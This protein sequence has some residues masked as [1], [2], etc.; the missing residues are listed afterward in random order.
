[1]RLTRSSRLV[2]LKVEISRR[3][4]LIVKFVRRFTVV[5]CRPVPEVIPFVRRAG[6]DGDDSS[7]R[8]VIA[9][10]YPHAYVDERDGP[11]FEPFDDE[12]LACS[13]IDTDKYKTQSLQLLD[14]VVSENRMLRRSIEIATAKAMSPAAKQIAK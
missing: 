12:T 5:K 2:S 13:L 9:K 14:G 6:R 1:M 4:R 8:V 7:K 10:L 3:F 11:L